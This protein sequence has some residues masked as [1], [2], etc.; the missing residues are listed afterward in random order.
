VKPSFLLGAAACA[1][2]LALAPPAAAEER[3][4]SYLDRPNNLTIGIGGAYLPS[5]EGSD[6]YQWV[7]VGLV[8]GKVGGFGFITRGTTLT[9][10]LI[11]DAPGAGIS[12]DL[13]PAVNLR[14]DRSSHIKDPQVRALGKI[15]RAVELGVDAGVAKNRL[16][17]PYDSLALRVT[18]LHDV[19]GTHGSSILTPSI[20]YSTPLSPKTF[21]LLSASADHVGRGY[22]QT[23]FSIDPAGAVRSGLPV[24]NASSGWKNVRIGLFLVQTLTGNLR[25]PHLSLFAGAS[26]SRM[27][28]D[29]RRSPIVSVAGSPNQYLAAAGL[30]YSF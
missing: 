27:L 14:L 21:A 8:A 17:D 6:D 10:D 15:D 22:A 28:N 11:R 4:E 20:E 13:G 12:F 18:W 2:T 29:F 7:P 19:T 24:F 16:L 9:L 3:T 23:Y 30:A 26:Y 5:Y 1:L 25:R